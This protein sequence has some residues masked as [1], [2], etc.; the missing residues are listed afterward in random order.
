MSRTVYVNAS[1]LP[2]DDQL[3][4]ARDQVTLG[5]AIQD[6]FPRYYSYFSTPSFVFRGRTIRNHNHLVGH[7]EG[8]D[9]IKTGY[10]RASGFN[11]VT[12]MRRGNRHIVAAVIGGRSGGARDARMRALVEE[13][14][15]SA[16][17]QRT[18]AKITENSEVAAVA[19]KPAPVAVAAK[20]AVTLDT[21]RL[22]RADTMAPVAVAASEPAETT[23][24]TAP[25][26]APIASHAAKAGSVEPISPVKVKTIT[27]KAGNVQ[28]A[29]LVPLTNPAPASTVAPPHF[30]RHA[31]AAAA[32]PPAP[33]PG[34]KPGVLG[35]L[36]AEPAAA[37]APA[38]YE[39]ASASSTPI[40][41][42]AVRPRS[43]W[44]IQIG[45]F[46][47]ESEAMERLRAAQTKGKAFLGKAEPFT[48]KVAKGSQELYRARFAGLNQNSAEAACKYFKRNEI[49]CM[50]IKN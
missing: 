26:P 13:Y 23:E 8:V 42:P 27:V 21:T 12:S 36:P 17:P 30:A 33:P 24:S 5:R 3:T 29:M 31:A 1:G 4:T 14:V 22:A 35:L 7:V 48:E 6:R 19:A 34:A 10:T 44:I 16:S 9:G 15:A 40:A 39:V 11:L 28:T 49:A 47:K 38:V 45:A 50:A 32:N 2:D 46:P 41:P 43:G 37:P 25:A 18:I 20:P